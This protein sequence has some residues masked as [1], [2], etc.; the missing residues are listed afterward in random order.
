MNETFL[1]KVKINVEF[2]CQVF[3][4]PF[5]S[6]ILFKLHSSLIFTTLPRPSERI[7]A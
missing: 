5:T 2:G 7:K 3:A 4:A 6:L 1:S